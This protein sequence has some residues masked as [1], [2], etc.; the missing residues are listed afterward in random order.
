MRK[1]KSLSS[2]DIKLLKRAFRYLKPHRSLFI[3]LIFL[4]LCELGFS[5]VQPLIFSKIIDLT[6]ATK[7]K[8]EFFLVMATLAL[9]ILSA[10]LSA[11]A[12]KIT[13]NISNKIILQLRADLFDNI[14]YLPMGIFDKMK[15][16]EFINRFEGDIRDLADVLTEKLSDFFINII[17]VIFIGIIV[18]FV[19]VKMALLMIGYMPILYYVFVSVGRLVRKQ[20]FEVKKESDHYLSFL[21]EVLLG[22]KEIKKNLIEE[23]I[24]MKMF[25]V[26]ERFM[27][28]NIKRNMYMI[29]GQ[30]VNTFISSV[31]KAGLFLLGAYEISKGY[32]T[33]GNFVAFNSYSTN[34]QSSF[35]NSTRMN[36]KLQEAM[37]TI[38][39]IFE[40][41]DM[42][43]TYSVEKKEENYI[44]KDGKIKFDNIYFAY[45][46]HQVL[47]GVTF[48][49]NP[50]SIN[51]LVGCNGCG[52]TTLF[53][54][55]IRFYNPKSGNIYIDGKEILGLP[56]RSLRKN[57]AYVSQEPF[58]F[59][60]TIKEN[61][62]YANENATEEEIEQACIKAGIHEY[63]LTLKKG[64]DS[65]IGE[66]GKR[67]STGQR[68]R[69][70]IA[71]A[72]L[73]NRNIILFDEPTSALDLQN[74]NQF[75][76][77]L[78]N[79]KK[80][81]TILIISHDLEIIEQSEN[82]IYM[83]TGKV[84]NVGRHD[85]LVER[86]EQYNRFML[87]LH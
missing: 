71:K 72:I 62:L 57:I 27:N 30:F 56:E 48:D 46:K 64:Y 7:L 59:D 40:L 19:D 13:V 73:A 70:E 24:R 37:V 43:T 66:L 20:A 54:I 22:I 35:I 29:N 68:Q 39:R 77:L 5:L 15:K 53:N 51:T 38:K 87:K 26:Q 58:M 81:H 69:L 32:M 75:I 67:F 84:L 49:I 80:E 76:Q 6:I 3:I 45:D 85:E 55:L 11:I 14:L 4:L 63:I 16:G 61:L 36:I 31:G 52:K 50:K 41:F 28:A 23:K 47:R 42:M 74:K 9:M 34:F 25:R 60:G 8:E 1:V 44:V 17:K 82:V 65:E 78:F 18:F 10:A 79:L 86:D 12:G 83:D 21:Q 2:E 33:V